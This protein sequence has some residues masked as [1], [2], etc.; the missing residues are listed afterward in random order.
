MT[1][2]DENTVQLRVGVEGAM[3]TWLRC[4]PS[5]S[6]LRAPLHG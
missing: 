5:I 3:E 4:T 2:M 1:L 6:A